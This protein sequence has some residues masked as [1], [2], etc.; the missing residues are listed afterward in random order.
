MVRS[1][2]FIAED[3]VGVKP[4]LASAYKNVY[5]RISAYLD[6]TRRMP[7]VNQRM[8]AYEHTPTY[9]DVIRYI[10]YNCTKSCTYVFL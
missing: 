8:R 1:M 4:N 10:V 6:G 3:G 7:K 2:T 9:V 5:R